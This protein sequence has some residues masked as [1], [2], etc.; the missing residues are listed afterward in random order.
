MSNPFTDKCQSCRY[1]ESLPIANGNYGNCRRHAP[2]VGEGR[3]PE[4]PGTQPR[5]WCGDFE[6]KLDDE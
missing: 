5:D 2:A 1:W 3:N 4:W 6:S